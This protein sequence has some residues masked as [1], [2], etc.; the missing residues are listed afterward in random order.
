MAYQGNTCKPFFIF[1][2]RYSVGLQEC[3]IEGSVISKPGHKGN[4]SKVGFSAGDQ[5]GSMAG[6]QGIHVAVETTAEIGIEEF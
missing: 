3:S 2:R 6:T 1:R 4:I 5:L